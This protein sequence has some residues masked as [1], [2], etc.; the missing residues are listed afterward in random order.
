MLI[1]FGDTTKCKVCAF[2]IKKAGCQSLL[3]TVAFLPIH[4]CFS[5]NLVTQRKNN[6]K[7]C[8]Y[9]VTFIKDMYI[10]Y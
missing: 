9:L 6:G 5:M 4:D 1:L 10:N 7:F 3:R 8:D 2:Y